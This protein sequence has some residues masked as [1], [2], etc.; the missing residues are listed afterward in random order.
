MGAELNVMNG[1]SVTWM[2]GL[3]ASLGLPSG[4]VY[5][6]P[7]PFAGL[8]LSEGRWLL[9][10]LH[11]WVGPVGGPGSFQELDSGASYRG[12]LAFLRLVK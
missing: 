6:R 1:V 7:A 3:D 8:V 5:G 12:T 4:G 9:A 11:L 2:C 10:W